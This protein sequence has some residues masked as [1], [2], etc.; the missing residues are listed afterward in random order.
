M[1]C[2]WNT[3]SQVI[4]NQHYLV[5]LTPSPTPPPPSLGAP[6][7][8]HTFSLIT[9]LFFR[10]AHGQTGVFHNNFLLYKL[11]A[12]ICIIT[13]FLCF[14]SGHYFSHILRNTSLPKNVPFLCRT[15]IPRNP[16]HALL[17]LLL[18]F[19]PNPD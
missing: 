18:P 15:I 5:L 2:R 11:L 12:L 14:F 17:L 9:V 6:A 3:R 10:F 8:S 7:T 19:N 1:M 13:P 16:F 4:V